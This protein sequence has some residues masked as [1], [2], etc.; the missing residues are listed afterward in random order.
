[1]S[2]LRKQFED[3]LM[4]T[5]GLDVEY[6]AGEFPLTG[7]I[8]FRTMR[9]PTIPIVIVPQGVYVGLSAFMRSAGPEKQKLKNLLAFLLDAQAKG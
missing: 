9:V 4:E 8:Y 2:V 5:G 7:R 1:M 6:D 3:A